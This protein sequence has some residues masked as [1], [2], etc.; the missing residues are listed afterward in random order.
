MITDTTSLQ[1]EIIEFDDEY[2]KM[3]K[4]IEN[5]LRN[6]INEKMPPYY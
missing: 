3:S 2:E 4:R 5:R 6:E 1:T